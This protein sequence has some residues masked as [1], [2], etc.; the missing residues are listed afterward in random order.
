MVGLSSCP[1]HDSMSSEQLARYQRFKDFKQI[2]AENSWIEKVRCSIDRGYMARYN[3]AKMTFI[4]KGGVGKTSTI[5]SLLGFKFDPEY[6]S[7]VV[8]DVEFEVLIRNSLEWKQQEISPDE[9]Q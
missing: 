4:G 6:Y 3:R 5:R 9:H 1:Y 8:T 7:T 2:V